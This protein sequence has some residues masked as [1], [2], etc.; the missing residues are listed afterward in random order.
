[1]SQ[2]ARDGV[3]VVEGF[4]KEMVTEEERNSRVDETTEGG[5]EGEEEER[6]EEHRELVGEMER[7][8]GWRRG[9][10]LGNYEAEMTTER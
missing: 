10:G 3:M 7:V 4:G 1:M 6:E 8:R 9:R 5:D 2:A